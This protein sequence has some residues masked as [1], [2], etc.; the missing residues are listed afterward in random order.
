MESSGAMD[1]VCD[2]LDVITLTCPESQDP[3]SQASPMHVEDD[4]KDELLSLGSP[5]PS[6]E[7]EE[8]EVLT[9][10]DSPTP[11]PPSTPVS[12]LAPTSPH[13]FAATDI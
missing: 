11:S 9:L 12:L 6:V 5:A 3:I 8:Q 13:P 10:L 4:E 2:N 7:L 1:L